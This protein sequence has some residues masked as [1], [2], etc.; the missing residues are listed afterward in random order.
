[1]KTFERKEKK[2]SLYVAFQLV[3]SALVQVS[4]EESEQVWGQEERLH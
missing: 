3:H 2:D 1:M 4:A